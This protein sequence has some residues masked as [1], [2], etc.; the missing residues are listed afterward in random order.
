MTTHCSALG[1]ADGKAWDCKV[2]ADCAVNHQLL[3][4][5]ASLGVMGH[6]GCRESV[7]WQCQALY[8]GGHLSWDAQQRGT[9]WHLLCRSVLWPSAPFISVTEPRAQQWKEN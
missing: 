1:M 4:D 6:S 9:W 7:F 5:C 3:Q 8:G 2:L